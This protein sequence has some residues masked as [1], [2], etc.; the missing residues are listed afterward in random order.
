MGTKRN[1]KYRESFIQKFFNSFFVGFLIAMSYLP[2]WVLYGISDFFYILLRHVLKY[3]SKVITQNLKNSFPEKT[4]TEIKNLA[5]KFYH[6]L[7]DVMVETIKAYSMNTKQ[8]NKR[9]RFT[10]PELLNDYYEK[11]KGV[12][13][14]AMHYNNWE[15]NGILQK[16]INPKII[17]LYNPIRGNNALERFLLRVRGK[18]GVELIPVDKTRRMFVDL[19]KIKNPA[20]LALGA[21]QTSLARS[22]FWTIFMNQESPFFSG[23]E[24]IAI[25]TNYAVVFHYPRK[26]KRGMYEVDFIPL[27][28]NPKEVNPEDIMLAYIRKMEEIINKEPEYY[29]W[30]H[31]R[32]KH[33]RPENIPLT[34]A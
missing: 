8:M 29:L 24:K 30:S 31:R 32:W 4:E 23:P 9:M 13:M 11:G 19:A 6:H 5:T 17:A 20:A 1:D 3:R 18:W 22:K 15:W 25:H 21:D 2:F 34:L 14:I 27:F 26:V 28:D 7:C 12:I 10:N 16:H 33:K